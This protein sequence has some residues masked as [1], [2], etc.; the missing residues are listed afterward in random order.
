MVTA[1]YCIAILCSEHDI[2]L[3]VKDGVH[4]GAH[5]H[6]EDLK[7]VPSLAVLKFLREVSGSVLDHTVVTE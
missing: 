3:N 7:D 6:S 1:K 4:E 5:T 2:Q